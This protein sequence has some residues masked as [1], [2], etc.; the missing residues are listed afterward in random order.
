MKAPKVATRINA[1]KMMDLLV[2]E[3]EFITNLLAIYDVPDSVH[4]N[5][6]T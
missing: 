3:N 4:G 5:F 6:C 2:K 1:G